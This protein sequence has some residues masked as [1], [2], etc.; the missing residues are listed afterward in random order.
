MKVLQVKAVK[1][2]LSQVQEFIM[3]QLEPFGIPMDIQFQIDM[4]VEEIFINIASYSYE[5]EVGEATVT[6]SLSENPLSIE[7]QF[8]DNGVPFDPL[9]KEDADLSVEALEERT[10]GLG[11]YMV[12]QTMDS[13]SY[14]YVNGKNILTIGKKLE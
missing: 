11:I 2:N 1:E 6:C 7:I 14:S 10:G 3:D 13:V 12:K 4:A 5:N 9:A 8:L